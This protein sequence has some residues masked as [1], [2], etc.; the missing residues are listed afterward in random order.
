MT[1]INGEK[2]YAVSKTLP[3]GM[4]EDPESC[5]AEVYG[6]SYQCGRKRGHG[7]DGQYCQQHARI[8]E[9]KA[10]ASKDL[11]DYWDE[12][13]KRFSPEPEDEMD[14]RSEFESEEEF[15]KRL[16]EQAFFEG[17]DT[18]DALYDD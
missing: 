3:D 16:S 13:D 5:V 12:M 9:E 1:V 18:E 17:Y 15:W 6:T 14:E 11:K 10:N 2:R 4:P 8:I 7:S